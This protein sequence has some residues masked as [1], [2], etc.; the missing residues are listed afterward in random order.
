MLSSTAGWLSAD[1]RA[2]YSFT[3]RTTLYAGVMNL[4]DANYRIHG[5][6]VDMPG[7]NVFAGISVQF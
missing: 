7:V 4:L 1:L 2:G 3:E 5:S 6:G